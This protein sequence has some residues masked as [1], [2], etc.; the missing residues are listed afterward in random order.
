MRARGRVALLAAA[1]VIAAAALVLTGCSESGS[2]S[3]LDLPAE[4]TDLPPIPDEA[5]ENADVD[6][7]RHV[8]TH[9]LDELYLMRADGH[10]VCLLVYTRPGDWVMGCGAGGLTVQASGAEYAVLPDAAAGG[11]EGERLSENV[12]YLPPEADPIG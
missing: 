7:A 2:F 12:Y 8:A 11:G 4:D 10:G 9:H 1:S 6:T 5:F 3:D